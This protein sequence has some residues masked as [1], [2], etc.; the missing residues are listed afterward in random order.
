MQIS[1][2]IPAFIFDDELIRLTEKCLYQLRKTPDT[3]LIVVDDCSQYGQNM[4]KRY[5]DTYIRHSENK[6]FVKSINDGLRVSRGNYLVVGNN[7]Y[8]VEDDWQIPLVDIL[9][10][11]QDCATVTPTV[12]GESTPPNQFYWACGLPGAFHMLTRKTLEKIGYHDERFIN[13]FSDSDYVF[14]AFD[15]NMRPYQTSLVKA[16]HK[17]GA[18]I[19]K[20][21][22]DDV[23]FYDNRAKFMEKWKT[24]RMYNQSEAE[25]CIGYG[26]A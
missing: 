17:G 18:T 1:V 11:V 5:A 3:E 20:V 12:N 22:L 13:S 6:G 8:I 24:H 4:M 2:V 9:N 21:G 16:W 19:S 23:E 15:L 25:R 26:A 7:D 10:R 14:R